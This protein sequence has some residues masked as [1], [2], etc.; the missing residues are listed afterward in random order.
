MRPFVFQKDYQ[1]GELSFDLPQ[2]VM[3]DIS[4]ESFFVYRN[5]ASKTVTT[6][7][8]T[9]TLPETEAFAAMASEHYVLTVIADGGDS[10]WT[11][12]MNIDVDSQADA[13]NL[14][15]S[16]GAQ[17]QSFSI[18]GLGQVATVTLTALISKNTVTKKLKTASKMQA[19]KVYKTNDNVDVQQTGLVYSSLYGTRVQ[20]GDIS[21]GIND[22]YKIH[23]IYESYDENDASPPYLT[24]TESVFFG[25]GKLVVGKTSGARGRV[26][27]FQN[28]TQKLY[29]V[30]INEIPFPV[31]Y[32]HL[33][34]PTTPYV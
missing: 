26:I 1:N 24:L 19:L 20:D 34:L 16:F 15:I 22:V 7:S 27:S 18:A 31:S 33:T 30:A 14:V 8:I 32:T 23:A 25:T 10:T 4:D 28:T 2:D 6:G 21:L 29:Y 3:K 9:F 12:G 5:F 13:G 17:N 11:N